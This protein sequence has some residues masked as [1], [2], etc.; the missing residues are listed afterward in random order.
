MKTHLL[1]IYLVVIGLVANAQPFSVKTTHT[2]KPD[3]FAKTPLLRDM[4]MIAPQDVEVNEGE[5]EVKNFNRN[6]LEKPS[7]FYGDPPFDGLLQNLMGNRRPDSISANFEGTGNL[8]N[9]LPPDTEGDVGPNHY[10]QMVNMSFTVYSK[11]GEILYGPASNLS[12][13]QH[14]PDPWSETSSGDPIVLYDER[15]DRWLVSELA[16]PGHRQG[17]YYEKIA[18][19]ETSDPTGAWYLY[20]YEYD[21]FCDYPKLGVWH[22]GYYMTANNYEW[23]NNQYDFHAV[24]VSV[25]ERD[26]MLIG[27]PDARLIF[28]DLYPNTVPWSMLPADFDGAPPEDDAPHYLAVYKEASDDKIFIYQVETDWDN[29]G[30]SEISLRTTLFPEPFTGNLPDGIPQP[31]GAPYLAPMS[32][33]LMYRLQYRNFGDYETMVANH[34]VNRGENIAGIRWY[35]FRKEEGND[36]QI[37]QEGTYSPD[38]THRWMGSIAMDAYGNIALGYSVSSNRVYPG[39]RFT[40]RFADDPLGVMTLEEQEIIEGRG[41]QLHSNHRWGDYSCMSVDPADQTHFWYTQQYYQETSNR[42]WKTRIAGF[43]INPLLNLS[44]TADS[45]T[46]CQGSE[47]TLHALPAGGSENYTFNWISDPPGFTSTEQHPVVSPEVDTRYICKVNDGVNFVT[48]SIMIHVQTPP[49]AYSGP[50]TTIC[51]NHSYHILESTAENHTGLLWETTGDGQFSDTTQLHPVYLPGPEDIQ[52]EGVTLSLT[53]QPLSQCDPLTDQMTLT[54]DPCTG[55]TE[56]Q[57]AQPHISLEPNPVKDMFTLTVK[58]YSEKVHFSLL[59]ATGT[60]VHQ[61]VFRANGNSVEKAIHVSHLSPGIYFA[62]ITL[63][64]EQKVMKVV[65][66]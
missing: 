16:L 14:A 1:I 28:L 46:V 63:G 45:N 44:V 52:N 5:T 34:T 49:S 61:A 33:R 39:V 12:I 42:D 3:Y 30:N 56:G 62:K 15:A 10:L 59:N 43:N 37:Y 65:V 23:V 36:W 18:V 32:N 55:F 11:S 51:A 35:E 8:Q 29:P 6:P 66:E 26:S 20:G 41:V 13:W 25:F 58:G 31:D 24:G 57:A 54:I 47:T 38:N 27:S 60:R 50:D 7:S 53:A 4:K 40:G 48:D 17:P 2:K 19:S 9:V 64:D 22:D 21:Y